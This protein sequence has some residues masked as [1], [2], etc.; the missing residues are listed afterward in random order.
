MFFCLLKDV[1]LIQPDQLEHFYYSILL[2][3]YQ[4]L[5]ATRPNF[6]SFLFYK[7]QLLRLKRQVA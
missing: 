6:T 5:P 2:K 4:P 3:L 1:I 7:I